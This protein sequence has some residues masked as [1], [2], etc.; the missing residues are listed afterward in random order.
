MVSTLAS[1][2]REFRFLPAPIESCL[3][4]VFADELRMFLEVP[5]PQ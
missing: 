3:T 2:R 5:A 4:G 1:S